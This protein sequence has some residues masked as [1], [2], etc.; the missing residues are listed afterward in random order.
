[1]ASGTLL[2]G[3]RTPVE[4]T[5]AWVTLEVLHGGFAS[6]RYLAEQPLDDDELVLLSGPAAS[7][8]G[9]TPRESLNLWFLSDSRSPDMVSFFMRGSGG[10]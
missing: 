10:L 6:G 5:P 1:M 3:S 2:V 4:N 7:V 8:A 9:S